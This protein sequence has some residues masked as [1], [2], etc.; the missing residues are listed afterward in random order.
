MRARGSGHRGT[1]RRVAFGGGA[2]AVMVGLADCAP[3]RV[4]P[5]AWRG[6]WDARTI[7]R[8]A[9]RLQMVDARRVDTVLLD[10][11]LADPDPQ[12]RART[13][14]AV[15]QVRARARYGVL[16]GWLTD[17]DS[18]VA[19]TA[20]FALG[21]GRD[22]GAV[23]VLRATVL[24]AA[25]R[26]APTV[27]AE[28]AWALGEIGEPARAALEEMLR[29]GGV[30]P[31]D[32]GRP[33]VPEGASP[34][35][36]T[37]LAAAKLRPVP[38]ALVIPWLQSGRVSEARAAAYA[39]ARNR[40]GAAV[41]PMLAMAGHL[42]DEVR[43]HVARLLVRALVPDTLAGRAREVLEA[44]A[45]D[46]SERVRAN[47]ARSL[48]TF[49]PSTMAT[50]WRLLADSARN[51][52][53][54]AVDSLHLV[55]GADRSAWQRAWE[56]D[57]TEAVRRPL[58]ALARRVGVALPASSPSPPAA[59]AAAGVQAPLRSLPAS[60]GA[61]GARDRPLAD[62]ERLVRQW[63][64]PGARQPRAVVHTARGPIV[65]ELRAREAPLVVEAF[66]A[67]AEQ[68]WY[69]DTRFHR[70]VPNFVVQDGD[71]ARGS[72]ER[73][74]FALRESWTRQRHGRGCLGLAT[75]GPD[76]GGS[77]FYFCHSPQPHLDGAYT[78]FGRIVRGLEV[79]DA[80]VQGDRME[81]V[82]PR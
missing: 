40:A 64:R 72:G 36:M 6:G 14:L 32:Q 62:Y 23:P 15:G 11:L 51:V 44:L 66:L 53:V 12:L 21:I 67:L 16:R 55:F 8:E 57:S 76:T 82:D 1:A 45:N 20:A 71:I 13:A 24:G 4:G 70:V 30:C 9:R 79:M 47:A 68:G 80:I 50:V 43:Q 58:A 78:V 60:W 25:R 28:A 29:P 49:G 75:A 69:R 34:C 31:G 26:D 77:Q 63:V 18:A 56:A 46:P 39:L 54:A 7:T 2:L 22:T 65:V 35:A 42:D 52:R 5:M 37:L 73:L 59:P 10:T 33:E 81:R 27:A 61:I 3:V 74:G 41:G 17:P 19:A 38:A 48:T